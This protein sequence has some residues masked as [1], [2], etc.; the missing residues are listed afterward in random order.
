MRA[1]IGS[2][3]HIGV[4]AGEGGPRKVSNELRVGARD[5]W[6][7]GG[8]AD[9]EVDLAVRI[10]LRDAADLKALGRVDRLSSQGTA[11]RATA[12]NVEAGAGLWRGAVLHIKR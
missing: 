10:E 3:E 12:I 1:G 2:D 5:V 8:L 9:Q 11:N 6:I 4:A 7:S